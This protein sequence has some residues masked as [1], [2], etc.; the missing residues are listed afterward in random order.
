M[1]RTLDELLAEAFPPEHMADLLSKLGDSAMCTSLVM[2]P[3][4]LSDPKWLIELG[5]TIALDK[6]LGLVVQ[7]G[8]ILPPKLVAVADAVEWFPDKHDMPGV[9]AAFRRILPQ[10]QAIVD[11]RAKEGLTF[12]P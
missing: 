4:T 12:Q 9:E 6:P 8:T 10:L 11:R 5:A 7:T 3:E 2:S 1:S